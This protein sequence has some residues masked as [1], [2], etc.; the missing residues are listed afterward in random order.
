MKKF[1]NAILAER[2]YS[3]KPKSVAAR[4]RYLN[5]DTAAENSAKSKRRH[6]GKKVATRSSSISDDRLRLF[7][8]DSAAGRR[9]AFHLSRGRDAGD[10]AVR[11]RLLVGVVVKMIDAV[12]AHLTKTNAEQC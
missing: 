9:I 2:E 5:S 11:E 8:P 7:K 10:I 4:Q 12:Q 6:A 1:N 3:T